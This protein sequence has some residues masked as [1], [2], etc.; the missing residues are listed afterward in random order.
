MNDIVVNLAGTNFMLKDPEEALACIMN[1]LKVCSMKIPIHTTSAFRMYMM[2]LFKGHVDMTQ[3]VCQIDVMTENVLPQAV[4]ILDG[5]WAIASKR[6]IELTN[7]C[8][9]QHKSV[10]RVRFP[11]SLG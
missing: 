6:D 9:K 10:L 5:I 2:E 11:L 3:V 8:G 4:R 1:I 7:K